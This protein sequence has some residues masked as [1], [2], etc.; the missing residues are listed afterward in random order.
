MSATD[1]LLRPTKRRETHRH[2]PALDLER[3]E[4]K[5]LLRRLGAWISE[6][7][8]RRR[9]AWLLGI[10]FALLVV[11]MIIGVIAVATAQSGTSQIDG[12]GFTNVRD[13]QGV[14]LSSYI[15]ATDKGGF[16]NPGN[17]VLWTIL[18][19]LFIGYMSITI[20]ASWVVGFALDFRWLDMFA[21]ALRGVAEALTGQ[22]AIPIVLLTA[23]T[24]GAFFVAWFVARGYH[25]KATVQV[26]TMV[27]VAILGP[28]ALA[29][30]LGEVLSSD[31]LLAQGR[32]L[33]I[34]VAAGLN[35]NASPNPRTLVP[36]MQEDL[37]DNFARKPLQVWNFGHVVDERPGCRAAWTSGV[38]AGSDG[39]VKR[40]IEDCGDSAAH[41]RANNPTM[42]Q[43]GTG[44]ILLVCATLLLMFAVYLGVRIMKAALDCIYHGFLSIFGFAAGGFVYG[45]T[46]TFLVRNIVDSFVAA[47][48]MVVFTV[49]LGVYMLFMGNL[50]DQARGQVFAVLVIAG[51]VEVVAISQLRSLS[52]G[53][54]RGNDWIA[55]RFALAIQGG[56]SSGGGGGGGTALGMGVASAVRGGGGSGFGAVAGLAALNTINSS[57]VTAW[58][59][60]RTA[61]PL[62]P[63]ARGK[64]RSE[65]ANIATAQHR[66]DTHQWNAYNRAN[67]LDKALIRA[68]G[69]GGDNLGVGGIGTELGVAAAIDGLGDSRVPDSF[70]TS[71]LIAAGASHQAAQQGLRALA[72]QKASTSHNPYGFAPLQKSIA[73][74]RAV[75]N[76]QDTANPE[77]VRVFA[78]QA[79]IAA[80]NF[81]RHTNEPPPGA[82]IDRA[83]VQR[84]RA[85]WDDDVALSRAVTPADWRSVN[86]FTRWQIG[87]EV[88][89]EQRAAAYAYYRN[90]T[91]ANLHNLARW[92]NRV[93]NLDHLHPD[94]GPDPW[95][96]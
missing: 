44:L 41:H 2:G 20:L 93:A 32:D 84:V 73:A 46:Q 58:L 82:R 71:T 56:Q 26:V 95:D 96:S 59:A 78:A 53:L 89:T 90:P 12:L 64:K 50:F 47:V 27:T 36:T 6:R 3:Y 79:A 70:M 23:A 4:P 91:D 57:P 49:F 10:V 19:L 28:I 83:F 45:P 52:K 65:L 13:S 30:P 8:A 76:H 38:L 51:V 69:V 86:R 85:N 7:P 75:Q 63:L 33:G 29:D 80:D 66:M 25:A 87:H 5:A 42:G 88:A 9:V 40:A 68:G 55:N 72:V 11:P 21:N 14:P 1:T 61:S 74:A 17:T 39:D 35:G 24:I 43:V 54:D 60:M 16:L 77:V 67:W 31:G 81:V 34:S 94:S 18:G 48:R 15:F 62:N 37:A 22:I 92:T